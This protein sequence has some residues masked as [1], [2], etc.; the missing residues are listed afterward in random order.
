[1]LSLRV[2]I[3]PRCCCDHMSH[4]APPSVRCNV[5]SDVTNDSGLPSEANTCYFYKQERVHLS[6]S[7]FCHYWTLNKATNS[8]TLNFL[9]R[10]C[11]FRE[12]L[13][14]PNITFLLNFLYLLFTSLLDWRKISNSSFSLRLWFVWLSAEFELVAS[15]PRPQSPSADDRNFIAEPLNRSDSWR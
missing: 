1:M 13:L 5:S 2:E 7:Y 14:R 11:S 3:S 9:P 15:D 12:S 6:H 4:Y 8:L 10:S